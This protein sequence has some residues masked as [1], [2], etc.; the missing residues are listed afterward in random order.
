MKI[1]RVEYCEPY[2]CPYPLSIH[3][4]KYFAEKAKLKY[5]QEH[6]H[7]SRYKDCYEVLEE[8]LSFF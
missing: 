3:V 7:D 8:E 2:E 4:F 1:Y 6:P 5:E